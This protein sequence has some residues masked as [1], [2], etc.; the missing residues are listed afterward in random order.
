MDDAGELRRA[1]ARLERRDQRRRDGSP[2]IELEL[3]AAG[4]VCAWNPAAARALGWSAAEIVGQPLATLSGEG[5]ALRSRLLQGE[6][7]RALTRRRDGVVLTCEWHAVALAD[8]DEPG[9]SPLHCELRELD[10]ELARR[11]RH[12]FMQALA[13]RSPLGIFAKQA[14]GRYLYVNEEFARSV[15]RTPEEVIGGDDFAIFPA[16]IAAMLRRHDA[17]LLD[18][19]VPLSREDAGVGA[20]AERTYWS[21]KF[22]LRDAAG[23]L[24]A[25]CGIVND[26][27]ELRRGE[28]ERAALQ[29]RVIEAQREAL[30]ELSTP[31]IPVAEGVLVM[32]LVGSIDR[33]RAQQITEALL[34]GVVAQRART[35]ILDITGVRSVDTHVAE[36]LV[37][38]A[39]GVRLLGAE[40]ILTG[41]H[42][43][44][45]HTLVELG[46][47]LGGL[48]TV[49]DLRSAVARAMHRSG[50]GR[51]PG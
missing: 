49:S 32:P 8:D 26:I 46:V 20:D 14:D 50:P 3:D 19:D 48:V 4:K 44:V 31:L 37:R 40:A 23:E 43:A 17:D 36:T 33:A 10:E 6:T 51:R 15:G 1:L 9:P 7:V 27:T 45:A 11:Q 38:A 28:Q 16:A 29:Q 30:A 21:L 12:S 25:I 5:E 34:T 39:Q 41:I 13:D 2:R 18:A 35:V 22:P 47:E 42:P 24:L